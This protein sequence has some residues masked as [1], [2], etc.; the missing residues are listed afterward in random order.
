MLFRQWE[1]SGYVNQGV[2]RK[3]TTFIR[4]ITQFEYPDTVW[5]SHRLFLSL[6]ASEIYL[7]Q[8]FV[9]YDFGNTRDKHFT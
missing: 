1:Y 5:G 8:L 7:E 4:W 9:L 6:N 2:Y 3:F